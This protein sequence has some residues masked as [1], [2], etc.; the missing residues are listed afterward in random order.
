MAPLSSWRAKPLAPLGDRPAIAHI[1]VRVRG[2]GGRVV[3]N[4]Y[5]RADEVEAYARDAGLLV[6]RELDLLGTAG[7]L[8]R[9]APLLGTGDVLVWNGD[10]IG[11]LDARALVAAHASSGAMATLVVHLR[12]DA[13]GNTGV[14]PRGDVVR[15]RRESCKGGEVRSADFL[16]V[17]VLGAELRRALPPRGGVIEDGLLPALRR[18]GRVATFACQEPLVDIGTP[19]SYLEAN[20][21][22]L[23]SRGEPGWLG[24]GA[25]VDADVALDQVVIGAGARVTGRGDVVRC[26]VWPGA[27]LRAPRAD[28]IVTPWGSVDVEPVNASPG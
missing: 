17:Y 19:G 18:G 8:S 3:V 12:G 9:A 13:A 10:M 25:T 11:E 2:L 4:A 26:V 15:L 16:G 21:R 23:A 27:V 22:W 24:A 14:D 20:L 7:G 6:S 1:V 28:A 5:H